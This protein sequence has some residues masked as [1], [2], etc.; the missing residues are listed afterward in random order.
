MLNCVEIVA[1]NGRA[2]KYI[3]DSGI[4]AMNDDVLDE[5]KMA[6]RE[7]NMD[8]PNLT[9]VK[10]L[11]MD[12]AN[13]VRELMSTEIK[14]RALSLMVDI[15]TNG[16]RSFLGMS[17]QDKANGEI[18]I[19]R[20]GMIE[21]HESHTALYLADVIVKR[22]KEFDIDIRQIISITTDNG[23]NML[24]MVRDMD[25]ILQKSTGES[26]SIPQTPKKSGQNTSRSTERSNLSDEEAID[27]EIEAALAL[28][29]EISEEYAYGLLF[30]D[31][32]DNENSVNIDENDTLL[33]AITSELVNAHGISVDWLILGVNC[34]A[35]TKQLSIGDAVKSTTRA[36][37][38]VISLCR[39]ISK[40][41]RLSS[42][43]YQ[44]KHAQIQYKR[45]RLDVTTRW[46]SLYLM[47][48][49]R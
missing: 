25:N 18:S 22:L 43:S 26:E 34:A 48:N 32:D 37:R 38:N 17:F 41:L 30:G 12:T 10:H 40:H 39:R 33:N 42:T 21:L 29:E 47:V 49:I 9:D 11:L 44:L 15:G 36:N 14:G 4:I 45:P 28:E 20:I 5:L 24:K 1:V 27:R 3:N 13:K 31:A 35:H 7:V 46:C 16:G 2:F 19:E 8:D 6:G 23:A